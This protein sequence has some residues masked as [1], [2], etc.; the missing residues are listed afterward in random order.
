MANRST[1]LRVG[2]TVSVAIIILLVGVAWIGQYRL[3]K[4]GFPLDVQFVNVGGLDVGDPVTVAGM[5][6][7]KVEAIRLDPDGV[8]VRLWLEPD[9]ALDEAAEI[10]VE[11]V[12]LMGERYVAIRRGGS[13]RPMDTRVV[14]KGIYRPALMEVMGEL[15]DVVVVVKEEMRGLRDLLGNSS[16]TSLG[17][18]VDQLK[19]TLDDLS[20]MIAENRGDVREG[21]RDFKTASSEA[22]GLI[23]DTRKETKNA[24]TGVGQA[25]SDI[26]T[27]TDEI[28][29]LVRTLQEIAVRVDEG[30]GTLGKLVNEKNLHDEMVRVL[31]DLDALVA[32]L[33]ENPKKYFG[34][35]IF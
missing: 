30:D 22:R 1:E 25:V 11:S 4:R 12:G 2:I 3:T 21:V 14:Q 26:E 13:V 31:R 28:R 32:D 18:T 33:K 7:G 20:Q 19:H 17:E 15:G 23:Q 27:T 16:G 9:V 5:D 10:A 6:R 34:I 29:V 24:L 8:Q 35:S